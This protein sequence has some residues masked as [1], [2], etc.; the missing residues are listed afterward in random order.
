M[1]NFTLDR[2][3]ISF[4]DSLEAILTNI[5]STKN[6]PKKEFDKY[7]KKLVENLV[8]SEIEFKKALQRHYWGQKAYNAFLD[9]ILVEQRNILVAR[10]FFRERQVKFDAKISDAIRSRD[11]NKLYKFN[12]NY[13]FIK[14]VVDKFDWKPGS[15]IPKLAEKV[16]K[17]R[18]ELVVQN[19]PLAISRATIFRAKTPEGHLS[20]MD[21]QN[22]AAEALI[23]SVDKFVLPYRSAFRD[24]I[25]GRVTGDLI[26][27]YSSTPVHFFPNDKKKI[28][29]ARKAAKLQESEEYD[30]IADEVNAGTKLQT[31]ATGT[32]IMHL[33]YACS[34]T[35][36][37]TKFKNDEQDTPI[38]DIIPAP[39]EWQPDVQFESTENNLRL[40]DALKCLTVM[41]VKLL[42]LK[43]YL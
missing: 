16:K 24:V 5:V 40:S 11:L 20:F 9:Y 12:V 43:G 42:K 19:L 8:K 29:R 32:E 26:S 21:M 6:T 18:S 28:Y 7:Q 27:S 33:M 10:T 14:F 4:R 39:S 30:K 41:E 38:S 1:A 3:F 17:Y 31:E 25:I 15:N 2:G 35:S 37:E 34:P 36:I 13:T 22:I 23:N